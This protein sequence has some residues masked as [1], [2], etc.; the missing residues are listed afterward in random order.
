MNWVVQL[1]RFDVAKANMTMSGFRAN[2]RQGKMNQGCIRVD[3]C[4][5]DFSDI[6]FGDYDWEYTVYKGA[7][8]IIPKDV[9]LPLGKEVDTITFHDA[10]LYHDFITGR[11]VTG[12]IHFINRTPIDWYSKKQ[13]TVETSTY[14]SEYVA[15]RIAAEQIIDLRN[16]LR[17]LGVPI[18]RSVLFGDNESVVNS[19]TQP[20]GK[21]TKRHMALSFHCVRECIAAKIFSYLHIPSTDNPADLL[22]KHWGYSQV[23]EMLKLILFSAFPPHVVSSQKV[24]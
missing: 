24:E 14:G 21:L 7:K 20:H 3:T 17:Y 6:A 9:P 18:A 11:S 16:T 4:R 2:P 13:N 8:E 19:S 23:W 10:N 1:G 22:S 12:I 15:A 5:Y